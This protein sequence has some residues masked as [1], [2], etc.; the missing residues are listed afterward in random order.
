MRVEIVVFIHMGLLRAGIVRLVPYYT[1][2]SRDED[3]SPLRRDRPSRKVSVAFARRRR[4]EERDDED[5]ETTTETRTNERG[6]TMTTMTTTPRAFGRE[7]DANETRIGSDSPKMT[8]TPA[9]AGLTKRSSSRGMTTMNARDLRAR[10]AVVSSPS[11]PSTP[12]S[13]RASALLREQRALASPLRAATAPERRASAV[14]STA[15]RGEGESATKRDAARLRELNS[16]LLKQLVDARAKAA[17][18]ESAREGLREETAREVRASRAKAAEA[19]EAARALRAAAKRAKKEGNSGED[20][21]EEAKRLRELNARLVRE[22]SVARN[23]V[24]ARERDQDE[25]KE[26]AA[27]ADRRADALEAEMETKRKTLERVQ[28]ALAGATERAAAGLR[29]NIEVQKLTEAN[30]VLMGELAA[31]RES[32]ESD[33][34]SLRA[35]IDAKSEALTGARADLAK[36]EAEV[37]ALSDSKAGVDALRTLNTTLLHQIKTLRVKADQSLNLSRALDAKERELSQMAADLKAA[38][39]AKV[40]ADEDVNK[41]RH[42]NVVLIQEISEMKE[43][44]EA[45]AEAV[46]AKESEL[47]AARM[48]LELVEEEQERTQGDVNKLRELNTVV[49]AQ[50]KTLK[51]ASLHDRAAFKANLDAK[52]AELSRARADVARLEKAAAASDG[53]LEKALL[54]QTTLSAELSTL[55]K[56][57]EENMATN[58]HLAAQVKEKKIELADVK[59]QLAAAQAQASRLDAAENDVSK[60]RE[61][62]SVL[63]AQVKTL[64]VVQTE[65]DS[66]AKALRERS[67]ELEKVQLQ[68]AAAERAKATGEKVS[69]MQIA[70]LRELNTRII[71]R[72]AE[73]KEEQRKKFQQLIDSKSLELSMAKADLDKATKEIA[74]GRKDTASLQKNIDKFRVMNAE[75]NGSIKALES[76]IAAEKE[77]TAEMREAILDSRAECENLKSRL[78]AKDDELES[79]WSALMCVNADLKHALH[80]AS[81][82]RALVE[83]RSEEL[84]ETNVNVDRLRDLNAMLIERLH[85]AK[86]ATLEAEALNAEFAAARTQ[87]EVTIRQEEAKVAALEQQLKEKDSEYTST[88]TA[89]RAEMEAGNNA[90]T[91]RLADLQAQT[92]RQIQSLERQLEYAKLDL[93]KVRRSEQVQIEDQKRSAEEIESLLAQVAQTEASAKKDAAEASKHIYSLQKEI[94]AQDASNKTLTKKVKSTKA[95]IKAL[96]E[97]LAEAQSVSSQRWKDL[98]NVSKDLQDAFAANKAKDQAM[99]KMR[100]ELRDLTN[101]AERFTRLAREKGDEVKSMSVQLTQTE[102]KAASQEKRI[103]HLNAT[104]QETSSV[105]D[106]LSTKVSALERKGGVAEIT[107]RAAAEHLYQANARVRSLEHQLNSERAE[108]ERTQNSLTQSINAAERSMEENMCIIANLE[109]KYQETLQMLLIERE[110]NAEERGE[111]RKEIQFVNTELESVSLNLEKMIERNNRGILLKVAGSDVYKLVF[112]SA[113]TLRAK[114]VKAVVRL[115]MLGGIATLACRTVNELK[116]KIK[117]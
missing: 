95:E 46:A 117:K 82:M 18:A 109:A 26:V 68:L 5:D 102:S 110:Q 3:T 44:A 80:D 23:V 71:Q 114:G 51:K 94:A 74:T 36:A 72:M 89:L 106:E 90:S 4:D 112:G 116:N 79:A 97:K 75:L 66:L 77:S 42:L 16:M 104:L 92:H 93:D 17:E 19:E 86:K 101:T 21:M 54:K 49:M 7:L 38:E 20:S 78:Q 15:T 10:G 100:V 67:G 14:K 73:V 47:D 30:A 70:N 35:Q 53:E 111:M 103:A 88:T 59:E 107:I 115:G 108:F 9:R 8:T 41:L 6:R 11:T 22:V 2:M 83:K 37:K 34:D 65:N 87:A 58:A 28:M 85:R 76:E 43:N 105:R 98:A 60:L 33:G 50:I 96:E 31:L 45:S 12:L 55:K 27:E 1:S 57:A 52:S 84:E 56:I 81:G 48:A 62:N 69:E 13:A 25:M 32:A 40:D 29:A 91:Q 113:P 61:L 39:S 99:D 63:I 24:K 64:K